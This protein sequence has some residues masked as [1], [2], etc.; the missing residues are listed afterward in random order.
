[1]K[2][3]IVHTI[4]L[5]ILGTLVV[6]RFDYPGHEP[7]YRWE[8]QDDEGSVLASHDWDYPTD[9]AA[10]RSGLFHSERMAAPLPGD[11][12]TVCKT[13]D[14]LEALRKGVSN[15]NEMPDIDRIMSNFISI[16][17][18]H[19]TNMARELLMNLLE[20]HKNEAAQ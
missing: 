11:D 19:S 7:D 17:D 3:T 18:D 15:P 6:A 10:L 5:K 4:P 16:R 20:H 9:A 8:I 12:P 2:E 13:G 14:M 1:M